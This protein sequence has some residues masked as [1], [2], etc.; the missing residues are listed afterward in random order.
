MTNNKVEWENPKDLKNYD[1][2]E[3]PVETIPSSLK[4]YVIQLSEELQV[5]EDM[6]GTSLLGILSICNQGKY[7]VE[8]KKNWQEPMNIYVQI[9]ANSSERKSPTCRR[10]SFPIYDYEHTLNENSKLD[11]IINKSDKELLEGKIFSLKKRLKNTKNYDYIT[12]NNLR[13]AEKELANFKDL[14]PIQLIADD[15]TTE[16]LASIMAKN[17]EKMAIVSAEGGIFSIIGGRYNNNIPNLD[18]YLKAYSKEPVKIDRKSGESLTL[19]SPSLVMVLFVQPMVLESFFKN[20]TFIGRGLCARFLYSYPESKVGNRKME[21][22]PVSEEIESEY[23]RLI[24]SL[25][26]NKTNSVLTLSSESYETFIQFCQWLELQLKDDLEEIADWVGKLP[27]TVLRIAGNLHL[28]ENYHTGNTIIN[29]HFMKNAIVLAKYYIAHALYVYNK[30]GSNPEIEKAKRIIKI[31][32][33]NHR[34]GSV[35]RSDLCKMCRGKGVNN[36]DDIYNALLYLEE[37]N[38]IRQQEQDYSGK[39]RKPDIIIELNPLFFKG[40]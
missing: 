4:E 15:I 36:V 20:S 14:N 12:E 17:N 27:G 25:L 9:I 8:A 39:G 10:I 5:P 30:M 13:E 24:N 7:V 28:V 22:E 16:A 21:T 23:I 2:P 40:E 35:K 32:K 34:T 18:L 26:T 33:K 11:L 19:Y 37:N 29:T 38:Y 3:F 1:L 6:V 31:L